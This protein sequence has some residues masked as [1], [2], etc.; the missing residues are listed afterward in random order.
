MEKEIVYRKISDF[1]DV[2]IP[3]DTP[4]EVEIRLLGAIANILMDAK[5][6]DNIIKKYRNIWT[7]EI[8]KRGKKTQ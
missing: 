6:V 7:A 1:S 8:E 2:L 4:P 3:V 5:S